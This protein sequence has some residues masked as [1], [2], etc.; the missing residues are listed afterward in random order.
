MVDHSEELRLSPKDDKSNE[1]LKQGSDSDT[2]DERP[3]PE[4]GAGREAGMA[5]GRTNGGRRPEAG[6]VMRFEGDGGSTF[7]LRRRSGAAGLGGE[8]VR[9]SREHCESHTF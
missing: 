8:V 6:E 4:A 7:I 2:G 1:K 5:E 3:L 9:P